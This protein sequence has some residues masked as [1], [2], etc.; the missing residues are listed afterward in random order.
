MVDFF[1]DITNGIFLK[2]WEKRKQSGET[3]SFFF[4]RREIVQNTIC[5]CEIL[6]I[7]KRGIYFE[8]N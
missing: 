8:N 5:C 4:D 1:N 6:K 7:L 3:F 2:K